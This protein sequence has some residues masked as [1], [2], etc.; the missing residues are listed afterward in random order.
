[1]VVDNDGLHDMNLKSGKVFL[2]AG[3]NPIAVQWFNGP[4]VTPG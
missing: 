3:A 1:M 4:E 2:R